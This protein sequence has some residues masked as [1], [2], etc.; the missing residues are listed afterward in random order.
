MA[1]ER[2]DSSLGLYCRECIMSTS[3]LS[4]DTANR[5]STRTI[6]YASSFLILPVLYVFFYALK[7]STN[8]YGIEHWLPK[9]DRLLLLAAIILL[10]RIYTYKYAVSQ[11]AVLGRDI[12]SNVVNLYVT[13]P[14]TAMV[15]LP[16]LVLGPEHILGRKLVFAAP[17]QLGRFGCRLSSSSCR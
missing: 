12:I 16:I 1:G 14:A 11:R 6:F 7:V 5:I 17:G 2:T 15:V 3:I 13:Y 4:A 8:G 10:E 9:W